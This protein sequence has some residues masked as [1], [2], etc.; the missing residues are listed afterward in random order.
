ME[1]LKTAKILLDTL[2]GDIQDHHLPNNMM[3]KVRRTVKNKGDRERAGGEDE[4]KKDAG[5]LEDQQI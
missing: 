2:L 1:F 3:V 4:E 5:Y